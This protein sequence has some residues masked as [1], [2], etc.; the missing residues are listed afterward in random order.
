MKLRELMTGRPGWAE[1]RATVRPISHRLLGHVG[2]PSTESPTLQLLRER[3]LSR[4]LSVD[5]E[6]QDA[7]R[8]GARDH[9]TQDGVK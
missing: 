6:R 9:E 7:S 5:C 3:L 4:A 2:M 8:G 1:I